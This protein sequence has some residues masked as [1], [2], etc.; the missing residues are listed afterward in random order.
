MQYLTKIRDYSASRL[1]VSWW[2]D[3]NGLIPEIPM[4]WAFRRYSNVPKGM[5]AVVLTAICRAFDRKGECLSLIAVNDKLV[6]YYKQFGFTLVEDESPRF[7]VR[8]PK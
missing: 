1:G 7:M 3:D 2:I 6:E 8:V 5:G 4:F